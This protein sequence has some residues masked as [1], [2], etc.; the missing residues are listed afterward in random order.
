VAARLSGN[1]SR[2]DI[3]ESLKVLGW[4]TNHRG[5]GAHAITNENFGLDVGLE[6]PFFFNHNIDKLGNNDGYLPTVFPLPRLWLS[7]DFPEELSVAMSLSPGG[8]YSSVTTF[9]LS[10]QWV[11]MRDERLAYSAVF[12]YN[13]ANAF[14]G[15]L[16]AHSPGLM[17][18]IS[19]NLDIWQP[20]A[21]FGFI[22]ANGA[23]KKE[24]AAPGV[25]SGPYTA[26]ATHLALGF[27]LDVMAQMVFQVD[28]IGT[29][30]SAGLLFAHRF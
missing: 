26:P 15:D 10:G 14:G 19:K 18:Q 25:D 6:V 28:L 13:Y 22:S 27:R 1:L 17:V 5:Y 2:A 12:S 7:W 4:G 30:P 16:I 9:G 11:F 23:V 29:R 21:A 3:R 8:L 24:L 20:F